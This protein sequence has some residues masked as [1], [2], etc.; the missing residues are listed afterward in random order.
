M[1]PAWVEHQMS[2]DGL[3]IEDLVDFLDQ[4]ETQWYVEQVIEYVTNYVDESDSVLGGALVTAGVAILLIPDPIILAVGAYF[5]G[6]SGASVAFIA[7]YVVAGLLIGVGT[8]IN[9]LD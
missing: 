4:D 9:Y 7:S 3:T 2:I 6:P 1:Y 5:G 8:L